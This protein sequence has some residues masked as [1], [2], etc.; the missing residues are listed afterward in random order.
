MRG[1]ALLALAATPAWADMQV[2][3]ARYACDRGV[4][5]PVAYVTESAPDGQAI[6]VLQV[7]G[8]QVLLYAE[9]VGSGARYGWP[10]DGSHYVWW[11]KG[12]GAML[13]WRNGETGEETTL[14]A[15]CARA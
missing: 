1:A 14:L 13:L 8:R 5:V 7:E 3:T 12:E 15:A 10:S 6:A 9:P 11:T 2:E 4:E